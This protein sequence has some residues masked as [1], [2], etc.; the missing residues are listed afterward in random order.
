MRIGPFDPI[1]LIFGIVNRLI[2][3]GVLTQEDAK[4]LLKEA[5]D[6][7]MLDADKDALVDSLFKKPN[8]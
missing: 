7:Q 3:K 1:D 8:A 6:P 2:S 5:L 4:S